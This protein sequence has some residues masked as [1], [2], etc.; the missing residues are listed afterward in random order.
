MVAGHEYLRRWIVSGCDYLGWIWD[1]IVDNWLLFWNS[2]IAK[3]LTKPHVLKLFGLSAALG[4]IL[5]I[6]IMM[7]WRFLTRPKEKERAY[8][9]IEDD[10][11]GS[12]NSKV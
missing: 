12:F 4:L 7:G 10:P 9:K 11:V 6:A 2:D 3:E 5:P 8:A 1:T